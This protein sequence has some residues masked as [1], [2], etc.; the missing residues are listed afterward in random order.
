MKKKNK[1]NGLCGTEGYSYRGQDEEIYTSDG[2][3]Q[4]G[5]RSTRNRHSNFYRSHSMPN[6]RLG[7]DSFEDKKDR[8]HSFLFDLG[9]EEEIVWE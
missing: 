1:D 8:E 3:E 9:A 4:E 7:A 5:W 2:I 6:C